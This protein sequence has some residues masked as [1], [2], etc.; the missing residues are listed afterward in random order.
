[1]FEFSSTSLRRLNTCHPDLIKVAKLAIRRSKVDFGISFGAR[2]PEEQFRLYTKGRIK[3]NGRWVVADKKAVVTNCDGFTAK[4]AHNHIPSNAFDVYIHVPGKKELAYDE[5]HL[6]YVAGVMQSCAD[7]LLEA[8]EIHSVI[9]WGGN[10]DN[11]GLIKFDQCFVD[12][13]HFQREVSQ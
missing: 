13:P 5:V 11:D 9:T 10:W 3:E 2:S 6:S 12:M 7:E 8:G 1:M 4:S